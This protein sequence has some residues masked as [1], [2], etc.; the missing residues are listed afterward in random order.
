[1]MSGKHKLYFLLNRIDDAREI[2][3]S[4]SIL[5][6]D[7]MNNLGGNYREVELAQLF[8]KLAK[9]EEVLKVLKVPSRTKD[10]DVIENL[11][12]FD[13]ADDGCW[14]IELL[15]TFDKYYLKI[16]QEPEYQEYSSRKPAQKAPSQSKKG[17]KYTRKAIEKIWDVLQEIEEKRQLGVEGNPIRLMYYPVGQ[18][19]DVG[20][21]FETR[22]TILENLQSQNA[23]IQLHKTRAG[24]LYHWTFNLGKNYLEVFRKHEKLYSKIAKQYEESKKTPSE[25]LT[26]SFDKKR[27]LLKIQGKE[28]PFKSVGRIIPYLECLVTNKEDFLYHSEIT[29][30]LDG[31]DELTNPKNTYY[32]VCRGIKRRLLERGITNFIESDYNKAR[33]NPMYKRIK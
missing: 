8:T 19:R 2:A 11:D 23:I 31:I 6:I 10:I 17:A 32:E 7:P 18:K 4:G 5:T 15:P 20:G 9:D 14:H 1:M 13:H 29:R 22:K 12:P 24:N 21:L 30:E 27:G 3:P 26:Y 33:I 28:I 25:K 16:Q